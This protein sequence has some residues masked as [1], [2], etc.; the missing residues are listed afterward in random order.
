[1]VCLP[2]I[3]LAAWATPARAAEDI[4]APPTIYDVSINGETYR[5]ELNRPANVKSKEGASY[6][7]RLQVAATQLL[8]LNTIRLEYDMPATV[9]DDRGRRQRTVRIKHEL[10][11]S[12]LLTELGQ[13]LDAKDQ[14]KTLKV[15]AGSVVGSYHDVPGAKLAAGEPFYCSYKGVS[16]HG[17]TIHYWTRQDGK[18]FGHTCVV[19]VLSGPPGEPKFTVTCVIQYLD[20]D[21][22]E[23]AP[24]VR[25]TLDSIRP[26]P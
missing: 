19:C 6:A 17:A 24:L 11:Y 1:M 26:L 20:E 7:L 3:L 14:E 10:G 4:S 21:K 12:I 18:D 5:L 2:A 9:T 13:P 16:G 15:L 25:K 23:V 22:D 8:R